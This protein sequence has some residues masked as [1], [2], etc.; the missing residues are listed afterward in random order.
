VAFLAAAAVASAGLSGV[1]VPQGTGAEAPTASDVGVTAKEIRIAVVA[2]V[3]N[4][5][6]PGL[7]KG[8]VDGV[9]GWAKSVNKRGGIAGRKVVVD[10]LDSK[11]SADEARNAV[12]Q[13]CSEDFALVGTSA[14]FLNNV[15]DIEGC[16]DRAGAKTGLPDLA[17]VTTEVEQQCSPTTYG[18]N[19]P[20]IVCATKDQ[21]PQTYQGNDG[22]VAYYRKQAG[23]KLHGV[24]VY[25][26]DI[27]AA[28][29][30]TRAIA[31]PLQE[32]GI[33]V[34]QEVDVSSRVPQTV[35]TPIIQRMKDDGSNFFNN[36]GPFNATVAARKEAKI[37]GLTDPN[38]I[39]DCTLQCYDRRLL[40]QGGA[41]VERQ[42]VQTGFLPF[43]EAASNPMLERF[44]RNVGKENA[45][46]F[47]A[48]AF[49]SGVLFEQAVE[50][51]VEAGGVNGVTR[52]ALFE[53]LATI[54]DFD[55]GGMIGTTDVGG[56]K[57]SPCYVLVQVQNG[58]FVRVWPKEKGT[59]D[60]K[61]SN[62]RL[63]KL[64][65]LKG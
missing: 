7:F 46:A 57:N 54:H 18:I 2:D 24:F 29:N 63:V 17:V 12:I 27:K 6:A 65:L 43:E 37:Q 45:D 53:Q 40:E 20:Q 13:A 35:Y 34:D 55:A 38:I 47:G 23:K 49:A 15:D 61:P 64:D 33:A 5:F 4:S 60:C 25:Q 26:S 41:D 51:A 8:S 42:Y 58:E 56:R 52:K 32:A 14:L 59:F 30:S 39:W 11:L 48:Q 62:R 44:L 19:P 1:A 36:G 22:R 21:H 9:Q 50:Q 28:N 16:V 3:D 31:A 10:F